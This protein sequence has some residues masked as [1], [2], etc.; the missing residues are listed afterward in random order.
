MPRNCAALCWGSSEIQPT[1]QEHLNRR[2]VQVFWRL[3]HLW[4]VHG[5][6]EV[7][8]LRAQHAEMS[9]HRFFQGMEYSTDRATIASWGTLLLEPEDVAAAIKWLLVAEPGWV[10]GQVLGFDGGLGSVCS[11]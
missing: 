11:R 8:L 4:F 7:D 2:S 9:D 10:T 3:L 1:P 6:E 5:N